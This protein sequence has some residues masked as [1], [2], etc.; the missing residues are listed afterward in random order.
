MSRATCK[1]R[2]N[3]PNKCN[4]IRLY[5]HTFDNNNCTHYAPRTCLCIICKHNFTL[6]ITKVKKR[7]MT[8]NDFTWKHDFFRYCQQQ[9]ETM[10]Y[11]ENVNFFC[12]H[13]IKNLR[14]TKFRRI[15]NKYFVAHSL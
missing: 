14:V 8:K 15:T 7:K 2:F 10:I 1:D 6:D 3:L 11:K 9:R 4:G 13:I 12:L 5:L